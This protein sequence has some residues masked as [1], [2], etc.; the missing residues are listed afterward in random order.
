MKKETTGGIADLYAM[1]T[2]QKPDINGNIMDRGLLEFQRMVLNRFLELGEDGLIEAINDTW[3]ADELKDDLI[4]DLYGFSKAYINW[5]IEKCISID[6]KGKIRPDDWWL[7]ISISSYMEIESGLNTIKD[8][9]KD[10]LDINEQTPDTG[11]TGDL[12]KNINRALEVYNCRYFDDIP[13]EILKPEIEDVLRSA[14]A[15]L[16]AVIIGMTFTE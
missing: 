13:F 10:I 16:R 4:D 14:S 11:D 2:Y 9:A 5:L 3:D 1:V 8:C 12:I 6:D 15:L 7:Y